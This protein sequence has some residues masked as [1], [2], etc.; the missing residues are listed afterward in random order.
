MYL[1]CIIQK[2]LGGNVTEYL[3]VKFQAEFKQS[4]NGKVS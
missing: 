4:A 1:Y 2:T 3:Y